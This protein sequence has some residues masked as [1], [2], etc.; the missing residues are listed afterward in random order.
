LQTVE[1]YYS[2]NAGYSYENLGHLL[3]ITLGTLFTCGMFVF[4]C[5]PELSAVISFKKNFM[6][7]PRA[8]KVKVDADQWEDEDRP[9]RRIKKN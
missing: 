3:L 4:A 6:A 7:P 1:L 9:K 5:F 8:E 2:K